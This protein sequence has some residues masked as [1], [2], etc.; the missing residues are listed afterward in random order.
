MKG[1]AEIAGGGFAGLAAAA[2]LGQRG[3]SVRVHERSPE[4]RAFGA[5]IFIWENGMRVLDALGASDPVIAG[6]WQAP[7]YEVRDHENHLIADK[8][9]GPKL[10]TRM[11]T[12]TRQLLYAAL[13]EAATRSGAVFETSSACVAA[14]PEGELVLADGSPVHA[15]LVVAA[16][17]V[18]SE[19]RE[20]LGLTA[21]RTGAGDFGAIRLLVSRTPGEPDNVIHFLNPPDQPI[22]RMLYVPC[23]AANVYVAFT[24][25]K[26]DRLAKS[27]PV[28]RE[29]WSAT[30]PHMADLF[31]RIGDQG[32]WD[33]YETV[34]L[35]TWSCGRVALI[36]D[37]AHGMAPTLGQGAGCAMMN[38]LALAVALEYADEVESGL[39]AWEQNDRPITEHTQDISHRYMAA[40]H[41]GESG[42]TLWDEEA[43]KTARHV[44][45]GYSEP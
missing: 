13:L 1:H 8:S 24:V 32:R 21:S 27:I 38:A 30:W 9:F 12:M 6:S 36:G 45:T 20:S 31:A 42:G 34:H 16:D 2:A 5:G 4:L 41:T 15:D 43:L 39:A 33:V 44:P 35:R 19:I 18:N 10:G 7:R 11:I 37:A 17:G 40:A 23:D 29:L 25:G 3:W 26:D 14:T 22:R 28:H